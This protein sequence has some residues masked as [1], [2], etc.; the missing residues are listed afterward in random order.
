MEQQSRKPDLNINGI[1]NAAGGEYGKVNI[2]G[3]GTIEGNLSAMEFD[4]N[5]ITK[6][7]GSL[8][9]DELDCDGILK[10][11]G[12]LSA[13]KSV[14]DGRLKVLGSMR[15]ENCR[16]NGTLNVSG[17]CELESF[18]AEGAFDISGLLNA[19][20]MTVKLQNRGIAREIG[21]E[22]MQVRQARKNMWSKLWRWMLPKFTPELQVATIE[23]D[24]IDLEYTVA[25]IVRGNRVVIGKG[26]VI[27]RVEYQ[28]EL[29]VSPGAKVQQEVRTGG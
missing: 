2:D 9:V 6:V 23:G 20:R 11:E 4:V 29:K 5:G 19:G 25:D 13:G 8:L 14:I 16:L 27:E 21:V 12:Q 26:C 7:R 18:D 24:D 10:V 17:D 3:I 15:G 22:Y 1:S 28:L